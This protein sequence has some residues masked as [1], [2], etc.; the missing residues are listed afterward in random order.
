MEGLR[1]Y[2]F[3]LTAAS[4]LCG[5]VTSLVPGKGAP[6]VLIRLISAIILTLTALKPVSGI[7]FDELLRDWS[8][9]GASA[10]AS[11][12]TGENLAREAM[13]ELIKS[14]CEAYILDKARELGLTL[15]VSV[16]LN[17]DQIPKPIAVT[18]QGA[19]SPYGRSRLQQ[20]IVNDMGIAKEDQTWIG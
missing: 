6:S 1:T 7:R 12:E 2:F 11:A 9:E 14:N 20:I 18:L 3:A 16:T 17:S 19:V 8:W 10:Y 15:A 4:V 13:A 5:I